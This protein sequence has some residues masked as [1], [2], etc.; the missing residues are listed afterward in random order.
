ML[1]GLQDAAAWRARSGPAVEKPREFV[2]TI[3]EARA[4]IVADTNLTY[5]RNGAA[6]H[7]F[8]LATMVSWNQA[9]RPSDASAVRMQA[10]FTKQL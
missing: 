8:V 4:I 1:P 7:K 6:A 2:A 5:S 9:A 3:N 10:H